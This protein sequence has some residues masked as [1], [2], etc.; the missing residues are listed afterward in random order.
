MFALALYL[1]A[2]ADRRVTRSELQNLLFPAAPSQTA[3]SHSLR[4]LL[5][6]LSASAFPLEANDDVVWVP[7]GR[8]CSAVDGLEEGIAADRVRLSL[9]DLEILPAYSPVFSPSLCD[10]VDVLRTKVS[11][12]I[13]ALLEA[14]LATFQR[15]NSW[16]DVAQ[17]SKTL[18]A[19]DPLHYE[20]VRAL[21]ES[22][23]LRCRPAE[24][25]VAVNEYLDEHA[26]AA[27]PEC[28][29][30]A[31][32]RNRLVAEMRSPV[33]APF[34]GRADCLAF[35]SQSWDAAIAGAAQSILL[36]GAAGIGK[37]RVMTVLS[38]HAVLRGA[39]CVRHTCGSNDRHRPLA[40][41]AHI[42]ER[43]LSLRGALGISP[44]ARSHIARLSDA[45]EPPR[46]T[47]ADPI[48][49]EVARAELQDALV[50]LVDAITAE[51]PLLLAIDDAHLLDT[52]SWS[53]LREIVQQLTARP[54]LLLLS[55]RATQY[56]ARARLPLR[57]QTLPLS[58]LS[59]ADSRT[60]LLTLAPDRAKDLTRLAHDVQ[61]SGGNPL[62]IHALARY[63]HASLGTEGV[64]V[65]ISVLAASAYYYLGQDTRTLMESVLQLRELA[66]LSR[67]RLVSRMD[68]TS[69]LTSLR[70]L[71][72]EGLVRLFDGGVACS[73]DL[74][75]DA[76]RALTPHTVAAVLNARIAAQ[77]EAECV[78]NRMDPTLAWAAAQAWMN[79]AEPSAASRL[80][81]RCAAHAA[82]LGEPVEAAGILGRLLDV[83]LPSEESLQL[84]ADLISHAEAGGERHLRARGTEARIRLL[85]EEPFRSQ[86]STLT[87]LSQLTVCHLEDRLHEAE[88]LQ[89]L[90]GQLSA[91]L[92]DPAQQSALRIRAAASL[93]ISADVQYDRALADFT[94]KAVTPLCNSLAS[95]DPRALRVQLIYN[96]V[97]GDVDK[98]SAIA[99]HILRNRSESNLAANAAGNHRSALFALHALGCSSDFHEPASD[100]Y[101][102]MRTRKVYSECVYLANL[103]ADRFLQD[104][105]LE[106][107][108]AWTARVVDDVRRVHPTAGG[109]TQAY[110]ATLAFLATLCGQLHEATRA[111]EVFR[112]RLP[113][114]HTPRFRAA[115]SA[116]NVRLALLKEAGPP[117]NDEVAALERAHLAG[118]TMGRHD[119]I[120]EAL[121]LAY[122]AN[123][124]IAKS[125]ELMREYLTGKRRE[126]SAPEWSLRFSTREDRIWT[127]LGYEA[128]CAP[129]VSAASR[130]KLNAV[131]DTLIRRG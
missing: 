29:T 66:T 94:W 55:T 37:T 82:A 89:P 60:L 17:A 14:D 111:L 96:T 61:T 115:D 32:L 74:I 39:R 78:D 126:P 110:Y 52:A 13:R 35:L 98:A 72:E 99:R 95:P 26:D 104:G 1:S 69:F 106:A 44:L 67:L 90:L 9:S 92:V 102:L 48:A 125:S 85:Q 75:A 84:T 20:A 56:P 33:A 59:E 63:A 124:E 86:A 118:S 88:D 91:I 25:L 97:F 57:L 127:Q 8:V 49:S 116:F 23:L 22:C 81:R 51:G 58:P 2:E 7:S 31:R 105:D 46:P 27:S 54:L 112:A 76:L 41:F 119:S 101:E 3:R 53:V 108:I 71:E 68:E 50:D 87:E 122:R 36:T 130:A 131:L 11:R 30:V 80:L 109:V 65:D 4:Q 128:V 45:G 19:L 123:G 40:L 79:A 24:A 28:A 42:A 34:V 113:L 107:S 129:H 93:L 18:L 62:L 114:I 120:V 38:D 70:H 6:R 16:D 100:I 103:I 117:C 83:T 47:S 10:W 64:P 12:R 21:T 73:H 15:A 5:Y 121:W 43:L 77:L